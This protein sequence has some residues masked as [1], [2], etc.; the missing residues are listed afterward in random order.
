MIAAIVRNELIKTFHRLAFWVGF[1]FFTGMTT[2]QYVESY[3]RAKYDTQRSFALPDAWSDILTNDIETVFIFSSVTL[4]LLIGN[5]FTWRT[6]RQN[7][8]DGVSKEQWFLGKLFL[9]PLML[10][11]FLGV[12][13]LL[14]GAFF[15]LLGREGS[16]PLV[17]ATFW[18]ALGGVSLGLVGAM[19]LAF[20]VVMAIRAA[21]ASMGVWLLWFA[22]IER[23]IARGLVQITDSLEPV[24]RFLPS[25]V[26]QSFFRWIQYDPEALQQAVERAVANNRTPPEIWDPNTLVWSAVIWLVVL[27]G[28]SFL[29][30]RRR[31]L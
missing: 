21:G 3:L 2:I 8:I 14:P 17:G 15:A 10:V 7:V 13:R 9:I 12:G 20:F 5:E 6:A 18:P 27:L 22:A 11:L 26:F 31:D 29:W 28:S 16:E 19:S 1:I 4:I 23:L 25:A 24:V 30:F